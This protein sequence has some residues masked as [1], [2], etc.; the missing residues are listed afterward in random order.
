VR[1]AE[2]VDAR[3]LDGRRV[4]VTRARVQS[5]SLIQLLEHSGAEVLH[6]PAIEILP[7]ESWE[8]LD[9]V[10][11]GAYDWLVFTSVNGVQSFFSRLH[12][13]A[14]DFS[15]LRHSHVA[16]VGR[17]T[18]DE[19]HHYGVTAD[20]VPERFILNELLPLLPREQTGVRTA[21]IRAE[22]GREEL[23]QELRQRGGTVDLGIAYRTVA[24]TRDVDAL[25]ALIA[26]NT[27]DAVTFTSPSTVVHFFEPLPEADRLRLLER[28]AMVAIGRST[29]DALRTITDRK[30]FE[31]TTSTVQ[32]LHDA[33]IEALRK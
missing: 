19:L 17:V 2:A 21:V 10:I 29:S 26:A 13:R 24:A 22:E 16:A 1:D 4:V 3:P 20:L 27:I 23:I 33:V 31:A 11:D 32:G 15:A 5:S 25:R 6:F 7:P 8:S 30:T 14:K 9:H 18:A 28:A 12:M